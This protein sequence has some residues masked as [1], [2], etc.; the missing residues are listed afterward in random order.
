[1]KKWPLN[2]AYEVALSCSVGFFYA[3]K[4]YDMGPTALL[5]FRRKSCFGFLLP[6]KIH[7]P[8]PG[9]NPRILGPMAITLPLDH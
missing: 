9:L 4:S 3:V 6:L 7:R 5:P 8:W 1:V 2:F